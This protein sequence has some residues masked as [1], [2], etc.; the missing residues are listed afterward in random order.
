MSDSTE[1]NEQAEERR[2]KLGRR[3][4][5]RTEKQL[6]AL[7]ANR[8]KHNAKRAARKAV[9]RGV[10]MPKGEAQ[11]TNGDPTGPQ[12]VDTPYQA[13]PGRRPKTSSADVEPTSSASGDTSGNAPT[14]SEN[15]PRGV[16]NAPDDVTPTSER[17]KRGIL[18][19][20]LYGF[21]IGE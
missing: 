8:A 11:P 3:I 16:E 9:D 2:D 10:N 7:A 6:A 18:G 19:E 14:T 21:G 17:P 4:P 1:P 5:P 12:I 20:I 13:K 15:A